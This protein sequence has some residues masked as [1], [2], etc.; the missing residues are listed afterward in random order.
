MGYLGIN[1]FDVIIILA[2]M[3]GLV[4]GFVKGLVRMVLSLLVLY[5]AAV[6]ALTFHNTLGNWI[7][8]LFGLPRRLCLGG[9]FL[10]ILVLAYVIINFVLSRTYKET[11][12]PGIRHLDQLGGLLVGFFVTSVWIGLGVLVLG[13]FL[14]ASIQAG[15]APGNVVAYFQRSN[16]V[17][18]FYRLVPIVL[19]TLRPWM[20]KG[21]PPEIFTIR[22]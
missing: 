19:A 3:V 20:P 10:I 13:F 2:L 14:G 22:L 4:L 9:A 17:G 6:L 21:L 12:L 8:Y 18:M 11:E 16:M 5:V 7:F 15:E 1:P